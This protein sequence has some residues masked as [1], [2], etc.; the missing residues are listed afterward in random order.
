VGDD[1]TES[2]E[3]PSASHPS[4]ISSGMLDGLR[5]H[6]DADWRRFV[7]K[8][9][10]LVYRWCRHAGL[11]PADAAEVTQ[12]AF[13]AVLQHVSRFS[14]TDR[15]STFRGWLWTITHRKICDQLRLRGRWQTVENVSD[16]SAGTP[17]SSS[18]LARLPGAASSRLAQ[19]LDAV[20]CRVEPRSW[21]AFWMTVV[22]LRSAEDVAQAL[23]LT[24]A[25]VRQA[26]YR[27][28]LHLRTWWA[29]HA[30]VSSGESV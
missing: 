14:R 30:A 19:A 7:E 22:E 15:D 25:A 3:A 9:S 8:Y 12:N 18:S 17:E 21:M 4:T 6:C 23:Q 27:T 2:L 5:T 26:K 29:E 24:P 11:Q 28:L 20:R 16:L 10:P 13:I 1:V